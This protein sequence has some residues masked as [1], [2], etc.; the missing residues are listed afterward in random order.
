[1]IAQQND[2]YLWDKLPVIK[3]GYDKLFWKALMEHRREEK[4][5]NSKIVRL[6]K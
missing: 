2:E 3:L 6:N 1:M 4:N 5:L